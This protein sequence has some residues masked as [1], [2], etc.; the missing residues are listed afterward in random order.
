MADASPRNIPAK[1]GPR[2]PTAT[3]KQHTKPASSLNSTPKQGKPRTSDS[4]QRNA[5]SSSQ[6]QAQQGEVK[7]RLV[8][9]GHDPD[10]NKAWM[11]DMPILGPGMVP[12]LS[13]PGAE[14]DWS[15]ARKIMGTREKVNLVKG[16]SSPRR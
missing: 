14:V 2:D 16:G 9:P 3:T 15:E 6:P 12:A 10:K 4:T 5:S 8:G 7:V 11:A 13:P 1:T